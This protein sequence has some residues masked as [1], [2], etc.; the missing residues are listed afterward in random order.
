MESIATTNASLRNYMNK[1]DTGIDGISN[2]VLESVLRGYDLILHALQQ[3]SIKGPCHCPCCRATEEYA[4]STL[5]QLDAE[6][7]DK[8]D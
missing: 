6:S 3:L 8:I 5:L 2:D 1:H 4:S 7:P